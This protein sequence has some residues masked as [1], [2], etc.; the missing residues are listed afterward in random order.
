[1][2]DAP[3]FFGTG[4]PIKPVGLI[5][6]MFR[7]SDDS[8]L[9]PFL[10]PSNIFAI[11]SLRQ[12]AEIYSKEMNN[13]SFADECS[14]LADEV[15]KAIKEYA[16]TEHLDFG[17]IYAYEVDGFGNKLFMDDANVPS[18]I[19]L[20]YIGANK[21]TDV[22]YRQTRK[23][24]LSEHNP[25]FLKGTAAEGQGGPHTG[26]ENI[27][28]MGIILR[29]ITSTDKDEIRQC[30]V[31]LKKTHAGT[32][33]IHE[34]FDKNNPEKFTRKWFAWAN[35]LFGELILKIYQEHKD[36]LGEDFK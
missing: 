20:T 8:T 10:I 16:I 6:S 32:G 19:S 14:R 1:M 7:P 31:W 17:Q 27:W 23:F 22:L 15:D 21:P 18:L 34:S 24:L 13:T 33:F 2:L 5:A 3:P 30:L 26:K 25:Y 36:L 4:H 29:A 28:P 35:T 9:F 12:L 11:I